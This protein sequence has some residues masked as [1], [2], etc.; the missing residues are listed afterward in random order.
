MTNSAPIVVV[1]AGH[2]G[3]VCAAY[4]A[5]AGR[6]VIVLEAAANVGGAAVTR[7]FAPGYRVSAGAHLL[8]LLDPVVTKDLALEREGLAFAHRHLKTISLSLEHASL[9]VDSDRAF[10]SGLSDKDA[11]ALKAFASSMRKFANVIARQ[12]GR[13][14]PRL[15]WERLADALPAASL[16]WDI[17]KLGRDDM[18]EFLRVATMAI[19]DVL[20][21]R[22]DSP[23]LKGAL[24]IDGVLGMQLGVRSG[25]T[26]LAFLHRSSGEVAGRAGSFAL[27]RGGMG[28]VT[29]T[30]ASAARKAGVEIRTS[31]AVASFV[32]QGS[33][34]TGVELA[35]G[36]SITA[37]AVV[38]SA[39]PRKTLL[40]LLG[41]RHLDTEFARRVHHLRDRGNAAKLHLALKGLPK[42]TNVEPS[43]TGERLVIAPDLD[44]IERAFN[45]SKYRECSEQPIFEISIPTVHDDS[46]AP[47]GGHVLSAIVQYAP[48]DVQGGWDAV[49]DGFRERVIDVLE[50][51]APGLRS[52]I[53]A[54]E[55]LAPPDIEREFGISGGHWHHAELVLDQFMMLRPVPGAAQYATPVEGL[56]LCGAGSHP[57]GGV[58]GTAGRNAAGVVLA[59]G[60]GR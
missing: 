26:L 36:E 15:A 1:G 52:Q 13:V 59:A 49:R 34:V 14:P 29:E 10:A 45:H 27:P 5:R 41:A 17:R 6:K 8:N 50:R 42:F 24:A 43:L 31:T 56:Y 60:V 18:R 33:R 38:S 4:L 25:N 16:A 3:L 7:E 2:N 48:Y 57:G 23:Q 44:Y 53:V 39:D 11:T 58:M 20:D 32:V 22:F 9:I 54:S 47:A 28:A 19:Q 12:H 55:L 46:L 30:L 35:T 21:E 40:G 51:Y 37:S